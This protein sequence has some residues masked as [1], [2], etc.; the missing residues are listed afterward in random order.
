MFADFRSLAFISYVPLSWKCMLLYTVYVWKLQMV[1]IDLCKLRIPVSK[2][3][4]NRT[5]NSLLGVQDLMFTTQKPADSIIIGGCFCC[6]VH[7]GGRFM[8]HL[9][10]RSWVW[11]KMRMKDKLR[12]WPKMGTKWRFVFRKKSEGLHDKCWA[13][14]F[15]R[16]CWV[17]WCSCWRVFGLGNCRLTVFCL[18]LT[19]DNSTFKSMS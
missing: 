7:A 19:N 1:S 15:I 12:R 5:Q 4:T 2:S 18:A 13:M 17:L 16:F 10:M 11:T 3:L 14:N 8:P 6:P 9:T